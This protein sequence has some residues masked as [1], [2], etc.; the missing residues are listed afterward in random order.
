MTDAP[1]PSDPIVDAIAAVWILDGISAVTHRRVAEA[2]GV[3]KGKL[4]HL[5]PTGPDLIAAGVS[6]LIR[7]FS[8]PQPN[9]VDICLY[10]DLSLGFIQGSP[11][12]PPTALDLA[13]V[14]AYV[15]AARHVA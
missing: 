14:E 7:P 4:Q 12:D 5:Y 2:A 1:P 9:W 6:R 8:Q 3:S 15:W 10:V 13:Q 11:V